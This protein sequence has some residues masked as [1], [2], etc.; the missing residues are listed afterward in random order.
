M[1]ALDPGDRLLLLLRYQEGLD[2]R[3][4][5]E[6]AQCAEGTVASGLNRARRRLR[7]LLDAGYGPGEET[8]AARHPRGRRV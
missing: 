4:I 1:A 3:T 5:A 8:G 6:V 7:G 2:Y